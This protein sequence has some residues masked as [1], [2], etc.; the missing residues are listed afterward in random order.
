MVASSA[1]S[2]GAVHPGVAFACFSRLPS[3]DLASYYEQRVKAVEEEGDDCARRI[4]DYKRLLEAH[5]DRVLELG[6]MRS[7]VGTLQRRLTEVELQISRER[8]RGLALAAEKEDI[9]MH[10]KDC[11]AQVQRLLAAANLGDAATSFP[12]STRGLAA[13]LSS[14]QAAT[15]A[16]AD[17]TDGIAL[18]RADSNAAKSVRA[19]GDAGTRDANIITNPS[20][21]GVVASSGCVVRVIATPG[22]GANAQVLPSRLEQLQQEVDET[23]RAHTDELNAFEDRRKQ[24]SESH[25][26]ILSELRTSLDSELQG[27]REE[28]LR[29]ADLLWNYVTL[30]SRYI[31]AQWKKSGE[32]DAL[33]ATSRDLM[34][35]AEAAVWRMRRLAAET[36]DRA[37]APA[38][39]LT[40]SD[41][42]M[43]WLCASCGCRN[44]PSFTHCSACGSLRPEE[45]ATRQL[46]LGGGDPLRA[47]LLDLRDEAGR[48]ESELRSEL[49]APR[50]LG[51]GSGGRGCD[52]GVHHGGSC[53]RGEGE[54]AV[55]Q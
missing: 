46:E 17:V 11:K 16:C 19:H 41:L 45:E 4:L 42:G 43:R 34:D 39:T 40:T 3:E 18:A 51:Y 15:K 30:R 2:C 44:T 54:R 53:W 12:H 21:A 49:S 50:A 6:R 38:I 28:R 22:T 23:A 9:N 55:R 47:R 7:K 8:L 48:S 36:Q 25:E 33:K 14:S 35:G 5:H 27:A 37:L 52:E 29:L 10:C 20:A 32:V 26:Q 24:D 31:S 13:A 1:D